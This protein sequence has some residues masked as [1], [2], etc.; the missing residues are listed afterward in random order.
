MN[1]S[2]EPPQS[3]AWAE[4]EFTVN[5]ERV[6][7]WSDA[8]LEAG[9]VSVQAED[10]DAASPA[11]QPLFGEPGEPPPAAGWQRTRLS[12]LLAAE[13]DADELL[14]AAASLCGEAVPTEHSYRLVP[15][16]DWV[17]ATQAQFEPIPIGERLWITPSWHLPDGDGVSGEG[18]GGDRVS[19]GD[20]ASGDDSV[21]GGGAEGTESA[22][23][24]DHAQ[25]APRTVGT[26]HAIVLDPG[27]A[28]GTG[29]HPTTRLCLEWLDGMLKAGQHVIDYGCG[30]GILAIAA[31]RLGAASVCA[32]DIDPQ[33][34]TSARHNADVNGVRLDIRATSQP[35]P[36]PADVVVANILANPLRVLAPLLSALVAPGGSLVLAG[37]LDRQADE[38]AACYPAFDLRP[39]RSLE[40]WTCLAGAKR[41]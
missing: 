37:L 25:A 20:C 7:A 19:G 33:A 15:D 14:A 13:L 16:Q 6:E 8:L 23:P 11:E 34:L 21:S 40:G 28:F 31:A 9:A 17:K 38:I 3:P 26:R 24:A 29:S 41:S 36:A 12:A 30:S 1:D 18:V 35:P 32:I 22:A 39:W 4:I 5:E 2:A 27:L 10:A